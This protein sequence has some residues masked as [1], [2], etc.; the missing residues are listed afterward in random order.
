MNDFSNRKDIRRAEKAARL[1]ER[2]RIDYIKRIMSDT[3][4]REWL[5]RLLE[6]CYIFGEPFI[7]G[8]PDATAWNLGRQN[9]GKEIFA[10][11]VTNC[12]TQYVMMMQ[13]SASQKEL[14]NDRHD[15]DERD[16]LGQQPGSPNAGRDVEGPITN[17]LDPFADPG[18]EA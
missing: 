17:E 2:A 8:A 3:A 9:V 13:E 18:A 14:Q 5:H 10:D 7:R 11:V 16:P 6:S 15:S 12:P 1:A 4:G